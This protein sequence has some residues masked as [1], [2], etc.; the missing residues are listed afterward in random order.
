MR[1]VL[2]VILFLSLFSCGLEDGMYFREP[3]NVTVVN[4]GTDNV[5]IQFYGY[6]QEVG[7]NDDYLFVGYDIFYYFDSA[8]SYKKAMVMHPIANSSSSTV[9]N[10]TY[11]YPFPVDTT[12]SAYGVDRFP[13]SSFPDGMSTFY[14][15]ISFPVTYATIISILTEG[16]NSNVRFSFGPTSGYWST[17]SQNNPYVNSSEH[18][19]ALGNIFPAYSDYS[20]Y[21]WGTEANGFLGFYDKDYYDYLGV[22]PVGTDNV[23]YNI[24]KVYFY[25]VA[26]GFNSSTERNQTYTKSAQSEIVEVEFKVLL[27]TKYS[28]S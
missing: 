17:T 3:R 10:N 2:I 11:L 12:A 19:V 13:T 8:A 28:G 1:A 9:T 27:S 15:T 24:Y 6:N 23:T 14:Q 20:G 21:S 16:S 5:Q 26:N 7:D 4:S 25:I 22:S 18:Y